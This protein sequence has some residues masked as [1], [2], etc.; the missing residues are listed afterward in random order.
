MVMSGDKMAK[1]TSSGTH[2]LV[3]EPISGVAFVQDYVEFH[4]DEKILRAFTPPVVTIDGMQHTFPNPGSR[5]ALCSLIQRTVERLS[6]I[7]NERIELGFSG[8]AVLEIPLAVS[9]SIGPEAAHFVPGFNEP[10]EVW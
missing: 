1:S 10:I 8:G 2:K 3:G 5:D 9:E 7:D 6:V 4:F